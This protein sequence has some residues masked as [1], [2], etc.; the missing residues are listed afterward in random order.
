MGR[1][2]PVLL[3]RLSYGDGDASLEKLYAVTIGLRSDQG[4]RLGYPP[5]VCCGMRA[6]L[7]LDHALCY[8]CG[9]GKLSSGGGDDRGQDCDGCF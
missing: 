1:S 7:D 5:V 8:T 3:R 2:N 4:V 6:W 9:I